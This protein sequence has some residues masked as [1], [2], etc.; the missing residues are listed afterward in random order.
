M[1]AGGGFLAFALSI[2]MLAAFALIAGGVVLIAKKRDRQRGLLMI[3]VSLV[4]IVNVLI[5]VWPAQP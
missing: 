3:G 1:I 2:A 5:W 4:L